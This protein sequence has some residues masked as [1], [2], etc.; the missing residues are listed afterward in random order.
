MTEVHWVAVHAGNTAAAPA[1]EVEA[2]IR[3]PTNMAAADGGSSCTMLATARPSCLLLL[4]CHLHYLCSEN[5]W[6]NWHRFSEATCCMPNEVC[7]QS[8]TMIGWAEPSHQ[9]RWHLDRSSI[10]TGYQTDHA[11]LSVCSKRLLLWLSK[12]VKMIK[13]SI[14]TKVTIQAWTLRLRVT[15]TKIMCFQTRA[16]DLKR[17]C[18]NDM[19]WHTVPDASCNDWKSSVTIDW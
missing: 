1:S 10:F 18:S 7:M 5:V 12:K 11:T 9:S 8:N 16:E 17:W 13:V 2:I 14:M 6:D 3:S 15:D 4:L 19:L